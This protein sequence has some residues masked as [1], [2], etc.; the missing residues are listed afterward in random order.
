MA[1]N[2]GAQLCVSGTGFG[3]QTVRNLSL[4]L[5]LCQVF[6]CL[7]NGQ[8]ILLNQ[9]LVIEDNHWQRALAN[10]Q[11]VRILVSSAYEFVVSTYIWLKIFLESCQG[12]SASAPQYIC[13]GIGC[14]SCNT[15]AQ[16]AGTCR[17]YLYLNIGILLHKQVNTCIQRIRVMGRI[18]NHGSLIILRSLLTCCFRFCLCLLCLSFLCFVLSLGIC[19]C[20]CCCRSCC[21]V[22]RLPAAACCQA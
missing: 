5:R 14:L 19:R 9:V 16:L 6:P 18:Y 21:C 1:Q 10:P 3:W 4:P 17:H 12:V 11:S 2:H 15:V 7:R 20:L 13:N 22:G 8:A